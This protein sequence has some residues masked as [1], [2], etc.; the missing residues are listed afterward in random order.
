MNSSGL[1]NEQEILIRVS[2]GDEQAFRVLYDHYRNK[3]FTIGY[4]VLETEAEVLDALQEVFVKLW[5]NRETLPEITNFNAYLNTVTRNHLYNIVRRYA[6]EETFLSELS[7][8]GPVPVQEGE[9]D[10]NIRELKHT[11]Q[12]AIHRLPPQQKRVFELSRLEGWKQEEIA[13]A[14]N[15]SRETVKR[16]LAEA[17]RNLRAWLGPESEALALLIVLGFMI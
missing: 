16:H 11:L 9:Q 2:Q 5:I 1:Y 4:K 17:M 3:V 15:I 6:Y 7:Q 10:I 12:K 13:A 8:R 14:M